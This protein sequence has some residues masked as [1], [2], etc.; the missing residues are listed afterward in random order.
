MKFSLSSTISLLGYKIPIIL[1]LVPPFITAILIYL[2]HVNVPFYDQWDLVPDMVKMRAGSLTVND[3]WQPHG[4]H[5]IFF[6][7][8]I[9]VVLAKFTGWD[10]GVE[11]TLNF[12][13]ALGIFAAVIY[14]V[15]YIISS[16]TDKYYWLLPVFS[17]VIFSPNQ[18]E[19]WL[20][21]FQITIFLNV[22]AVVLGILLIASPKLD[23]KKLTLSIFLGIIATYSYGTGLL[24]W[25]LGF[26]VLFSHRKRIKSFLL[27]GLIFLFSSVIVVFLYFFQSN[28]LFQ[29]FIFIYQHPVDFILYVF[30]FLGGPIAGVH[31]VPAI[32]AGITGIAIFIILSL[33]LIRKEG[34]RK[35]CIVL[36]VLGLYAISSGFVTAL[37]RGELGSMQAISSRYITIG[38]LLWLCNISLLFLSIK[39]RERSAAKIYSSALF[40]II[41]SSIAFSIYRIRNFYR[42]KIYLQE[43]RDELVEGGSNHYIKR[44]YHSEGV[45]LEY[46]KMLENHNLWIYHK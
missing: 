6:P 37:G 24:Y 23:W 22:F 15:R 8:I 43:A 10:I 45:L 44:L 3:L 41:L 30:S 29:G 33:E 20:W 34:I 26:T 5:R 2:F 14:L 12:I 40:L 36:I 4:G 31:P 32:F 25:I 39:F 46:K 28:S 18:W 9:M 11:L 7:K 35:R 16:K 42:Q 21:G 1:T 17:L 13:L 38:N 27:S 19:N